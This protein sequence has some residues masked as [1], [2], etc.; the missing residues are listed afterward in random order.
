MVLRCQEIA[1]A[2][3]KLGICLGC[4]AEDIVDGG[5][6]LGGPSVGL[7]SLEGDE[8]LDHP[9]GSLLTAQAVGELLGGQIDVLDRA[10]GGL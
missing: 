3:Q 10:A 8:V 6:Y 1:I 2:L 5:G 7:D 4:A 9:L